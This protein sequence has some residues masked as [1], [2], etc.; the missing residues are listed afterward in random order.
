M[1]LPESQWGALDLISLY[2][3]RSSYLHDKTE[4]IVS[5]LEKINERRQQQKQTWTNWN[6]YLPNNV[7]QL[8]RRELLS[9]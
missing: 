7:M 1:S 8:K 9:T 6:R 4:Q 2:S 3:R 5:A